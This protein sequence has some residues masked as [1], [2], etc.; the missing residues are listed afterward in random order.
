M[1]TFLKTKNNFFFKRLYSGFADWII[2]MAP[3]MLGQLLSH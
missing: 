2:K 1:S 3:N